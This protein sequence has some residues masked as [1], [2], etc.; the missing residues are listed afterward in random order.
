MKLFFLVLSLIFS[1]IW[2]CKPTKPA[3]KIDPA[4]KL[5]ELNCGGCYGFCPI[6]KLTF[7]NSGKVQYDG[8]RFVEKT[9]T[10]TFDLSKEELEKLKLAVADANLWQYPDRIQSQIVDAPMATLVVFNG[11]KQKSVLG[12]IDRPKPLLELEELAKT[13]TEAHEFRVKRGVAPNETKPGNQAELIVR[14]KD[15]VNAGNWLPQ[16]TEL[17]LRLLRRIAGPANTWVVAFDREQISANELIQV[18]KSNEDVLDAQ[19][20]VPVEERH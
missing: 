16:F 17:R 13:L 18:F 11:D 10:H 6:F 20:N 15:G 9:G 3:V 14:L 8:V 5:L 2:A 12:S 7:F 4:A 19:P 1:C